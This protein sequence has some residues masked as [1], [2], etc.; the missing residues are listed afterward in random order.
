MMGVQCQ[1]PSSRP[2]PPA[3]PR[4]PAL[5]LVPSDPQ[6]ARASG[7]GSVELKRQAASVEDGGLRHRRCTPGARA[8]HD[9]R[10]SQPSVRSFRPQALCFSPKVP[11]H[12]LDQSRRSVDAPW[13]LSAN[14]LFA[15]WYPPTSFSP[16]QTSHPGY[17]ILAV[18]RDRR[19][20]RSWQHWP[21][22]L[23]A[24]KGCPPPK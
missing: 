12:A 3:L 4:E 22:S 7:F 21:D 14:S 1:Y 13:F 2:R 23:S 20:G 18:F 5:G 10:Q 8:D 15:I 24:Y 6:S 17:G 19:R 11:S 9:S 16:L